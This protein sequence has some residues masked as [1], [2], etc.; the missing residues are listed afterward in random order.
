MRFSAAYYV[1]L[2]IFAIQGAA[3]ACPRS[4]HQL[5]CTQD[6]VVDSSN[7]R[8]RVIGINPSTQNAAVMRDWDSGMETVSVRTLAL[9]LGCVA[10]ACVGDMV[11]DSSNNVGKIIAVNP[12]SRS[13]VI[14][15]DWDS[16][17]ET[18][19][20]KAAAIGLGCLGNVCV[21]NRVVDSSNNTGVVLAV[22][23]YTGNAALKRDWDNGVETVGVGQL[24]LGDG[25]LNGV[26]MGD[27]VVDASNNQALVV[28]INYYRGTAA[29][30]R[31]WD[32]G[33]E[34]V[35]LNT[36]AIT[37]YCQTYG[38]EIRSRPASVPRIE[39]ITRITIEFD[40]RI[41]R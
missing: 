20:I 14:L 30:K 18:V 15:R 1:T 28:G 26:C 11:V 24:A 41:S 38:D 32:S 22:N 35:E 23:P 8:G 13:V 33:I 7:N 9:G 29:V 31:I 6:A 10:G 16:G 39:V 36:L 4:Q 21:G 40:F 37:N 19:S 27:Q 34:T 2:G 25:C 17:V 12:Y 3:L 5:I